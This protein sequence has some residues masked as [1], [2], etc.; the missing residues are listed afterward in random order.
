M[1]WNRGQG[2][3]L[4]DLITGT[5][6]PGDV[7]G[8]GIV[9]RADYLI[10]NSHVGFDNGTGSGT[11]ATLALGD[12]DQDGDVDLGDFSLIFEHASPNMSL[13]EPSAWL[14]ASVGLVATAVFRRR[15]A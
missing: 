6:I 3:E 11:L 13:P 9:D 14:L 2:A 4:A 8:N 15:R 1:L 12:V 5:L 7:D 10:W